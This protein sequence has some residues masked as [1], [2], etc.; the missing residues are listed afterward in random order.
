MDEQKMGEALEVLVSVFEG[1]VTHWEKDKGT[2]FP[3]NE[4]ELYIKMVVDGFKQATDD[5]SRYA[6]IWH[7]Y[8][9]ATG[10][11]LAFF[12]LRVLCLL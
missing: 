3:D 6:K 11:L 10:I 1:P 8:T 9:I 4:R 2:V 12:A 5:N 7:A